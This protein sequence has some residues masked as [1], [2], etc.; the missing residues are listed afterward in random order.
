ME[1]LVQCGGGMEGE[2]DGIE[3]GGDAGFL[4][5]MGEIGGEAVAQID[6]GGGKAA[7][8]EI[9]SLG[10]VRLRVEMGGQAGEQAFGD[11]ERVGIGGERGEGSRCAA[12]A[13]GDV[14]QVT[15]PSAGTEKRAAAR[16]CA[17]Q[18]NVGQGEGRLGQIAAGQWGLGALGEGKESIVKAREPGFAF[19]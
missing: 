7:A 1:G 18:N 9:K 15:G 12:Q 11:V 3:L 5:E 14:E 10:K 8:L 4:A 13:A 16:N 6:G 17:Y 2:T 19:C